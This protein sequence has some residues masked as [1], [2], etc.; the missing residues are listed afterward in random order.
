MKLRRGR[1]N[2]VVKITAPQQFEE[3]HKRLV[4]LST[5]SACLS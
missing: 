1:M 5:I 2:E 3:A 4:F